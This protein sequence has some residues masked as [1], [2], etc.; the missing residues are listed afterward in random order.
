MPSW[1]KKGINPGTILTIDQPV[2]SQWEIVKKLNEYDLQLSEEHHRLGL[3]LSLATTKLLCRDPKDHTKQAFM[4][5]SLQV[6]YRGTEMDDTDTRAKQAT[7]LTPQELIAYQ[8]LTEKSM[9]TPKLLG[10]RTTTQDSSGVVP[11]GFVVWLVWEMVPGL[12]LGSKDGSDVFWD[13]AYAEREE[14]RVSFVKAL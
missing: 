9:S 1:F 4:R 5:I 6:P 3:R 11:G 2:P 7:T 14:I 12:R 13:L 10:Y 8:E